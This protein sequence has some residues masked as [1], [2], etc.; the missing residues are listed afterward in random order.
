RNKYAERIRDADRA[1]GSARTIEEL[2]K[3]RAL[4]YQAH[5]ILPEEAYPR[6]RIEQ[7]D[8]RIKELREQEAQAREEEAKRKA[9]EEERKRQ[10]EEQRR[11][12]EEER[13]LAE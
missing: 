11:K 5:G 9:E 1:Y 13:R 3:A 4:Y 6:Q 10:E 2:A 7:I 8:A 12:E